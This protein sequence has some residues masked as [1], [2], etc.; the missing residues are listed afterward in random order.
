MAE[1]QSG[2]QFMQK[3]NMEISPNPEIL[4]KTEFVE[5]LHRVNETVELVFIIMEEDYFLTAR[6]KAIMLNKL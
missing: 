4:I 3:L 6:E 1:T 2:Y 5:N